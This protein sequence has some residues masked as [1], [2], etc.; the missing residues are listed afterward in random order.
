MA[1]QVRLAPVPRAPVLVVDDDLPTRVLLAE[2]LGRM[3]SKVETAADG[4]EALGMIG[5]RDYSMIVV[6]LQMPHV[7]GIELLGVLP[8]TA[9]RNSHRIV[10]TAA[11]AQADRLGDDGLC[12][13]ALPKPFDLKR[14][15][16]S[17]ER[18]LAEEHSP[19]TARP[20][21][22][23]EPSRGLPEMPAP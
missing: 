7:T 16:E 8:T 2:I 21:P 13:F 3:G 6:D 23:A 18:C 19:P 1:Q 9:S 11:A 10:F 14:F 20:R 12:C 22:G 5:A 17:V 15:L 4:A